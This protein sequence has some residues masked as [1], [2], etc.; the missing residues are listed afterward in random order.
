[1]GCLSPICVCATPY[2]LE[3]KKYTFI[4]KQSDSDYNGVGYRTMLYREFYRM[5]P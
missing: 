5:P 1:M 3:R 4:I 2:D